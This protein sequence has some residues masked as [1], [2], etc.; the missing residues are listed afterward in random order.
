M[1]DVLVLLESVSFILLY[2]KAVESRSISFI[3]E[4]FLFDW[5]VLMAST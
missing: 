5:L 4:G 3:Y 1:P 2:S